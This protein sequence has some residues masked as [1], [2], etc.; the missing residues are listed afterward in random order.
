VS[1]G[2]VPGLLP[3]GGKMLDDLNVGVIYTS[4][5]NEP[6]TKAD[7]LPF[8]QEIGCAVRDDPASLGLSLVERSTTLTRP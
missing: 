1:A 4:Q 2:S 3:I 7:C 5:G 8:L 6:A